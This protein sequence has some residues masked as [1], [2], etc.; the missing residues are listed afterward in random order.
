MADIKLCQI[1]FKLRPWS[2]NPYIHSGAGMYDGK[3]KLYV[4]T[5][6]NILALF[7]TPDPDRWISGL[8]N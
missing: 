4:A 1:R 6:E 7:S 2:E 3:L 8:E 5:S